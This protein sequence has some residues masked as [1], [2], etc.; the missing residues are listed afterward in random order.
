MLK[1]NFSG[2][3]NC[4]WKPLSSAEASQHFRS[5]VIH[6]FMSSVIAV[7]AQCHAAEI[8]KDLYRIKF[9]ENLRHIRR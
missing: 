3:N 1:D 2:R 6:M 5:V 4:L 7:K 8:G 9:R